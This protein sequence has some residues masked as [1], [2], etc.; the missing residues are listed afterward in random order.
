VGVVTG[1]SLDATRGSIKALDNADWLQK[2]EPLK[3]SGGSPG[4]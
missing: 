4:M 2:R 3:T 1:L